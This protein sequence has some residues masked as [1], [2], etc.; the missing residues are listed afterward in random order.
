[1]GGSNY[2]LTRAD[3]WR[4]YAASSDAY[5]V[6]F[7]HEEGVLQGSTMYADYAFEVRRFDDGLRI[8]DFR[9]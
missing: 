9:F 8:V 4:I 7:R 5:R 3:R 1:V 6:A 2:D